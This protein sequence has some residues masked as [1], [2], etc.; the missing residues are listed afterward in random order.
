VKEMFTNDPDVKRRTAQIRAHQD[1]RPK[2]R[3]QDKIFVAILLV[4]F[5]LVVLVLSGWAKDA[6]H[7][8]LVRRGI[9]QEAPAYV[10]P[11]P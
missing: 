2:A 6:K 9:I 7:K 3:T 1:A 10:T 8:D 11:S 5:V 4:V